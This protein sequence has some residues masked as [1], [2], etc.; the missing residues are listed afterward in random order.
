M[1]CGRCHQKINEETD[2]W[3]N[4][5]DFNGGKVVGEK[6]VHL[7]CWHNMIKKDITNALE[8]KVN[9]IMNMKKR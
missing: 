3:V 5:R 2:R 4:V 8:E 6:N 9:Q 1:K 7:V